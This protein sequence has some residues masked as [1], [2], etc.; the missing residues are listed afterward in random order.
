MIEAEAILL[1]SI[2]VMSPS[3]LK[4]NSIRFLYSCIY[5]VS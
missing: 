4:A 2:L 1:T 3:M 5:L